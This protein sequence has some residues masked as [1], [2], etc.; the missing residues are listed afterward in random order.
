MKE[1]WKPIVGYEG[2]YEVSNMGRV[3][4]LDH[5]DRLGRVIKGKLRKE[6]KS[7]NGYRQVCLSKNGQHKIALIHR[8]VASAFIDNPKRLPEVNHI[9]ENKTNNIASN[10]E[11]CTRKYNNQYGTKPMRGERHPMAK[12]SA[13]QVAEIREKRKSGILLKDIALDYGISTSHACGITRGTW[14]SHE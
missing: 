5:V 1:K 14:W 12:L 3:R 9:D 7:S 6:Q 13:K 4:S 11:W 2:L 10:L 8:L